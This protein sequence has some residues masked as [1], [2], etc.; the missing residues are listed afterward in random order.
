MTV[1][2]KVLIKSQLRFE[3]PALHLSAGKP[4]C[5]QECYGKRQ[6]DPHSSGHRVGNSQTHD[7]NEEENDCSPQKPHKI[8]NKSAVRATPFLSS[9]SSTKDDAR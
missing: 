6:Q 8:P 9:M 5:K 1:E 4:V 3:L 7:P 2:P